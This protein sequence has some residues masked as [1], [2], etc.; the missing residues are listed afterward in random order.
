MGPSNILEEYFIC[1]WESE[2][3]FLVFSRL[4]QASRVPRQR[5]K[6]SARIS[7]QLDAL[8][9]GQLGNLRERGVDG[10]EARV[11]GIERFVTVP[12]A[13]LIALQLI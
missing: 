5:S 11:E 7:N 9:N 10:F 13:A 1:T 6:I 4:E 2:C 3:S 8:R 12:S